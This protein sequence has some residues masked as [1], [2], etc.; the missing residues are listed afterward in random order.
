MAEKKMAKMAVLKGPNHLD[1]E[2]FPLPEVKDDG[3]LIKIEAT[4]ICGSD[5]HSIRSTP[6]QPSPLGHEFTGKIVEM[7]ERA[8][9]TIYSFSGPLK[10]GDR[11]AVYP[12][13]TCGTCP[14]SY[15]HLY[16][17]CLKMKILLG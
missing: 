2:S 1:I 15:T 6:A 8:N 5:A 14:V 10:V 17:G 13:I 3:M 12:W 4:S 11:I 9:E 7:G 16:K